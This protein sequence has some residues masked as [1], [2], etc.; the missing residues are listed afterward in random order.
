MAPMAWTMTEG[1][2]IGSMN[3]CWWYRA[4]PLKEGERFYNILRCNFFSEEKFM[5]M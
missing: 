5:I 1:G 2:F 4:T 3:D